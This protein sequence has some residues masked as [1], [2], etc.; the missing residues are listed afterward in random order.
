MI[1]LF[2]DAKIR[3]EEK[4]E[5]NM[6]QAIEELKQDYAEEQVN[7]SRAIDCVTADYI[8]MDLKREN[9]L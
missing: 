2:A 6:C 4:E 1:N 5:T 3:L 7:K 8:T 9:D